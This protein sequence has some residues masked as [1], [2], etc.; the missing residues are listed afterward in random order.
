MYPIRYSGS[1]RSKS[2][3]DKHKDADEH[4]AKL[5]AQEWHR[6]RMAGIMTR[7]EIKTKLEAMP[8]YQREVARKELNRLHTQYVVVVK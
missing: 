8:E 4:R 1:G 5:K 6:K 7:E 3:R 2:I